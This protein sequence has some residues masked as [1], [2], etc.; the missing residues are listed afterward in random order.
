[1]RA[2][3]AGFGQLLDIHE[4]I[5]LENEFA[6]F[7]LLTAFIGIVIFPSECYA[8]FAAVDVS[9]DV[10]ACS[11][12][13]LTRVA[14]NDINNLLEEIGSSMLAIECPRQHGI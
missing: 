5:P 14:L 2:C 7:I 1:V 13:A 9:D 12:C 11:H 8:A 6:F 3:V 10:V 4:Q